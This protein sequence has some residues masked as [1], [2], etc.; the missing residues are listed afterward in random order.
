VT[1]G[2]WWN[3]KQRKEKQD[4]SFKKVFFGG[5]SIR[6]GRHGGQRLGR[7]RAG[8]TRDD[9]FRP[10]FRSAH[11]ILIRG[12]FDAGCR[13]LCRINAGSVSSIVRIGDDFAK[14]LVLRFRYQIMAQN[15]II[16]GF[17]MV[18]NRQK[19]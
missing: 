3:F 9:G 17:Q 5:R 11:E 18:H 1:V 15:G 2:G 12:R 16:P 19:A 7:C 4:G 10:E 8:R 13:N 14:F 6:G